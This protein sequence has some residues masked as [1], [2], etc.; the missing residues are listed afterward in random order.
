MGIGWDTFHLYFYQIHGD[1]R[2]LKNQ[3]FYVNRRQ[4]RHGCIRHHAKVGCSEFDCPFGKA[5]GTTFDQID[6]SIYKQNGPAGRLR[7]SIRALGQDFML[8]EEQRKQQIPTKLW[9]PYDKEEK[10]QPGTIVVFNVP[11]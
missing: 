7:A 8:S 2:T 1:T 10:L 4:R 6:N 11:I 5:T 9:L 3:A